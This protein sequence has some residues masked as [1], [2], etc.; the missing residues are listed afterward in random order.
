MGGGENEG[1]VRMMGV[2]GMRGGES[3]GVVRMWGG[4]KVGVVSILG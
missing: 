3:G 1:V 4:V 2:I